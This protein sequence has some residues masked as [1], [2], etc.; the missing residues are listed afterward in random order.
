MLTV[1]PS[2]FKRQRL[3]VHLM[4]SFGS[5]FHGIFQ[6]CAA[7]GDHTILGVEG[8]HFTINNRPEFL[9]GFSYYG[10]LGAPEDFIRKDLAE[11]RSHGFNWLRVWATWG[12]YNTNVSAVTADGMPREPYLAR[13]KWL[14]A[15]CDRRGLVVDVTLSRS[16]SSSNRNHNG[17]IA[18]R[19][20][21]RNCRT[22]GQGR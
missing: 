21:G 1:L 6:A 5:A 12:A 13:L 8:G 10:A 17:G 7:Q 16:Q 2:L 20:R 3:L 19:T 18:D 15:E 11:L 4:L 14:V 9:L 22:V